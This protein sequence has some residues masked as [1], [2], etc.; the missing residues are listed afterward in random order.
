MDQLANSFAVQTPVLLKKN[1]RE[2]TKV[3]E[4]TMNENFKTLPKTKE[5]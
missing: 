5:V 4:H 3:K 2:L 1:V